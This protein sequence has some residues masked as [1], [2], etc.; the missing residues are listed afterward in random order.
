MKEQ[1]IQEIIDEIMLRPIYVLT[2]KV[3]EPDI[4]HYWAGTLFRADFSLA[5]LTS[6]KEALE[7]T[8][9]KL[10]QDFPSLEFAVENVVKT[11]IKKGHIK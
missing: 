2:A 3:A 1:E 5:L 4:K 7:K 8:R 10:L 11:I 9:R 6:D